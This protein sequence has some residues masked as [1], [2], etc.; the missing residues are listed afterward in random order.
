[1]F[2]YIGVR[3]LL[4]P[5]KSRRPLYTLLPVLV[6]SPREHPVMLS[7]EMSVETILEPLLSFHDLETSASTHVDGTIIVCFLT[8]M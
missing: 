2:G 1:M 8:A 6:I 5:T 4:G 3:N 7:G